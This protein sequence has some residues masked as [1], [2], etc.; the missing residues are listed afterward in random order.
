MA[1][2]LTLRFDVP[3]DDPVTVYLAS[4]LTALND[5]QITIVELVSG[6]LGGYCAEMDVRVHQP[7]LHTHPSDHSDLSDLEVHAKDFASVIESDLVI[8]L[9]DFPSWGGGKELAW[10]ERLRIPVLL[11][12][13]ESVSMSRL[14]TGTTGDIEVA[15]WRYPDDIRTKFRDYFTRRK[16]DLE[17]HRRLRADR[18]TVWERTQRAIQQVYDGLSSELQGEA[19]AVARLSERRVAEILSSPEA[20]A[21]ASLD[22]V[23][24]LVNALGLPS[25]AS[26][27]AGSAPAPSPRSMSALGVA[28]ELEG[29]DGRHAMELL[30]RASL[31]VARGGTRRLSFRQPQD[32][33]DFSDA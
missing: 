15:H 13:R 25:T 20:F 12:T 26:V 31:E 32:W 27:P 21:H 22:E 24:S 2:A 5:D 6:L 30:R 3:A 4:G 14:V 10:A 28:A 23:Q 16:R 19:A 33:I 11:L 7:V 18:R 8:A 29:W 17:S 9:G 1:E